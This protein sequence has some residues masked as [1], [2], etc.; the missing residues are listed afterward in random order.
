MTGDGPGGVGEGAQDHSAEGK[1]LRG[2]PWTLAAFTLSRGLQL[3][4]TLIIARLVAPSEIG[5]V[6]TGLVVIGALNL[7]SDNG[8]SITLVVRDRIDERLVGTVFT[9]MLGIAVCGAVAAA[10]LAGPI[11]TVFGEPELADVLPLLALTVIT[12]TISW[13]LTNLLQREMLWRARFAGQFALAVG[14]VV[15]AVPAAALGA[16][17]WSLVIGQI[18][19][20]VLATAVL[21]RA[22]PKPFRPQFHRREARI[23]FTESRPYVSQSVTAFF[24]ENLHFIAVSAFLGAHAMALYSMSFRLSE[25]PNKGLAQ[26]VAEATLPAYVALRHDAQRGTTALLTALRYV[27]LAAFLPL[28]ILAATAPDFISVILGPRWTEMEPILLLLCV[29]GALAVPAGTLN[30]FV[31]AGGGARYMAVTNLVRLFG[32]APLIFFAAAVLESLT[33]VGVF[34][35]VD[36][37]V[38]LGMISAYAHRRLSLP[39]RAAA[40]TVALPCVAA[41]AALA[42]GI[43]A[44]VG[45]E[46]VAAVPGLGRLALSLLA[47]ALAYVGVVALL[48]PATLR[49]GRALARRAVG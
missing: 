48:S 11:S 28:A 25:L 38:E 7:L 45:L 41:A 37:L 2:V 22:Y 3:V 33:A 18:A 46:H 40:R 35:C 5:V 4:G 31:N 6:L 19:A 36:V 15:V 23:A 27:T 16:G 14:Y 39:F 34:M 42:A 21:W 29:W 12:S 43:G 49:D 30:W 24:I 32:I 20:G 8:L 26:P 47:A 1:A 9:M 13:L 10:A 44:R 17:I